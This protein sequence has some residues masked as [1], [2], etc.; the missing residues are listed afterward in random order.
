MPSPTATGATLSVDLPEQE[1]EQPDRTKRG[2]LWSFRVQ[3]FL[4]LLLTGRLNLYK[5]LAGQAY[6]ETAGFTSYGFND[7]RNPWGMRPSVYRT[8]YW[9]SENGGFAVYRSYWKA[10]Q[11]RMDWDRVNE[12]DGTL[13]TDA[14]ISSFPIEVYTAGD[15]ELA[16]LRYIDTWKGLAA[17]ASFT[18]VALYSAL[19]LVG[20]IALFVWL[21]RSS[22][23]KR[24]SYGR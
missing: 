3:L 9:Q 11:D 15:G 6:Y 7:R 10:I 2:A 8:R 5:A 24:R 16:Q 22:K 14:Y 13:S 19:T 4:Y 17:R 21:V 1:A 18:M 20:I 12:V 23:R